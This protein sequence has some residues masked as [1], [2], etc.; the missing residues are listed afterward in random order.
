[1]AN[2]LVCNSLLRMFSVNNGS[3][4]QDNEPQDIRVNVR[5]KEA[6]GPAPQQKSIQNV[7][8]PEPIPL[9]HARIG[10]KR[11]SAAG[12]GLD[13]GFGSSIQEQR[14]IDKENG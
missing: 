14:G 9:H 5:D 1:M 2:G 11:D 6:Q 12:N 3:N 13:N 7:R 10:Y 8:P 4:G